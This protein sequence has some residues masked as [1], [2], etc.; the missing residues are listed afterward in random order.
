MEEIRCE[1]CDNK[2]YIT[3]KTCWWCGNSIEMP[4]KSR[5]A[6]IWHK[7]DGQPA[8]R[9]PDNIFKR[10]GTAIIWHKPDGPATPH[11]DNIFK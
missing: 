5:T 7:P 6:I 10:K 4:Q 11:P 2:N 3:E 9:H 8:I 1:V